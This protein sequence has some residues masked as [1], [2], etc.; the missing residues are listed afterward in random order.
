MTVS[1]NPTLRRKTEMLSTEIR[2]TIIALIASSSFAVS[3]AV[4]AV[5]SAR[6][7]KKVT[8]VTCPDINGA[9]TG[10][11]GE[12]RTL[13]SNVI[14]PDGTWGVEKVRKI[15]GSDGKWH[16]VVDLVQNG[17]SALLPASTVTSLGA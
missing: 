14:N 9:G 12:I 6:P 1:I 10:Q 7:V 11:A 4:P 3:S 8:G 15:C 13:E 2:T 17:T 5:S 16:T